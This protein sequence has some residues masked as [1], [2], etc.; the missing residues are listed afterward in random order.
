L[1]NLSLEETVFLCRDP[2]H[3]VAC[4]LNQ[5]SFF[6][7]KN[8]LIGCLV[9]LTAG[10]V[11]GQGG[12]EIHRGKGLGIKIRPY[13]V[14]KTELWAPAMLIASGVN[15][16]L[17]GAG[18][19]QRLAWT[20]FTAELGL[21]KRSALF[22]GIGGRY[23]R[24]FWEDTYENHFAKVWLGGF[25]LLLGYRQYLTLG[26]GQGIYVQPT[27]KYYWQG[28]DRITDYGNMGNEDHDFIGS[29]RLGWQMPIWKRLHLDMG[30]GPGIGLRSR[31]HDNSYDWGYYYHRLGGVS[32]LDVFRVPLMRFN[33]QAMNILYLTGDA[34]L[35]LGWRF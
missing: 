10:L 22:A 35:S 16:L 9:L 26:M 34:C 24:Y 4:G 28:H 1:P 7:M 18:P 20:V 27:L 6:T 32:E 15:S 3:G 17:D 12:V 29:V 5:N 2:L 19:P 21:G 11:L 33:D 25:K 14:V 30:V 23:R 13:V 31:M 8:L